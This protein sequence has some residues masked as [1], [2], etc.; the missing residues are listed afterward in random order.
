MTVVKDSF[1]KKMDSLATHLRSKTAEVDDILQTKGVES[2]IKYMSNLTTEFLQRSFQTE[3]QLAFLSAQLK[4]ELDADIQVDNG[5]EMQN[6][7]NNDGVEVPDKVNV[8]NHQGDNDGL[9]IEQH[10]IV[11]SNNEE[12]VNLNSDEGASGIYFNF[13]RYHIHD[14]SK[15]MCFSDLE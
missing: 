9:E 10:D 4:D 15:E 1:Q 12:A 8:E 7:G 6:Q 14:I 2:V 13:P 11:P 3:Y 5:V